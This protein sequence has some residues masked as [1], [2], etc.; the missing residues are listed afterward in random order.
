[1][2]MKSVKNVILRNA[3]G[4]E[5][6]FDLYSDGSL[7]C[8]NLSRTRMYE[9]PFMLVR[10]NGFYKVYNFAYSLFS[11]RLEECVFKTKFKYDALSFLQ[12][13]AIKAMNIRDFL[14]KR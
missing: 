2:T 1:M 14:F 10:E 4:S 5:F 8:F 9:M 12:D 6:L 11:F 3:Y 7:A 13:L